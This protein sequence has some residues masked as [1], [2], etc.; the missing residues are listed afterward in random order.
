MNVLDIFI[1]FQEDQITLTGNDASI[2]ESTMYAHACF[3]IK[4]MSERDEHI[5][6]ISVNLL[7]QIRDKFPQVGING[8]TSLWKLHIN[9]C[10][11]NQ[12]T[13]KNAGPLEFVLSG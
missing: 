8:Y 1:W 3:L 4:S 9:L 2:R 12:L 6:D 11:I 7:I 5:R 10:N 13:M